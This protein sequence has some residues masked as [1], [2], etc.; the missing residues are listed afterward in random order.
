[1]RF[2]AVELVAVLIACISV[3]SRPS[4]ASEMRARTWG[5]RDSPPFDRYPV[6][7]IYHVHPATIFIKA[8]DKSRKQYDRHVA[9]TNMLQPGASR[10]YIHRDKEALFISDVTLPNLKTSQ[11]P[12][13][14]NK[15]SYRAC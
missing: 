15:G 6:L 11:A 9:M 12:P 2:G 1:L 8:I 7:R 10:V 5:D 13:S 14:T 3:T 4:H